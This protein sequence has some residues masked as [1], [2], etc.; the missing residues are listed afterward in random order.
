MLYDNNGNNPQLIFEFL[1][2]LRTYSTA[3]MLII[4]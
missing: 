1:I 2:Y 3:Q 4:K